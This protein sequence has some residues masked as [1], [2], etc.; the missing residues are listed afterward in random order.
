MKIQVEAQERPER[1]LN[2]ALNANFSKHL[3]DTNIK[4]IFKCCI[5]FKVEKFNLEFLF[6]VENILRETSN[7][8]K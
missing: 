4:K 7:I 3:D 1:A 5:S 6:F 2:D 8:S